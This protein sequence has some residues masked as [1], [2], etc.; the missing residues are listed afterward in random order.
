MAWTT[1]PTHRQDL[2]LGIYE[3]LDESGDYVG[4]WLETAD[5]YTVRVVASFNGGS[6]ILRIDDGQYDN[7][8]SEPRILR[9]QTITVAG[10]KGFA[11]LA[12]S[13][14]YFRLVVD[15][16]L[17]DNPFAATVRAV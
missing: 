13:A 15:S 2:P 8:S 14:R 6:P 7:G 17:A 5:I 16:G 11:E 1:N 4:P 12:L 10:N 3:L 9:S